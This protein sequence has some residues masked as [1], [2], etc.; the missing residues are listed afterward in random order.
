[1]R[2]SGGPAFLGTRMFRSLVLLA[3]LVAVAALPAAA[4]GAAIPAGC[5]GIT[6]DPASLRQAIVSA[7]S[8]AGPDTVVLGDSCVY[9][10]SQVQMDNPWYGPNGLPPI[11][12]D[13][14][15]EGNGSTIARRGL[16]VFNQP[17]P[18]RLF[19]VGAD[20]ASIA[21][22][23]YATPGAGKLTLR[24]VMLTGGLA[25][26]GSAAGGGGGAGAG[27]AIFNQGTVVI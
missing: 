10:L 20:P 4:S 19:F 1:M 27:G 22:L 2:T 14:T 24:N 3:G 7:N 9:R 16:T 11:A 23:N 12:S 25:K 17:P 6:G 15:I 8:L 13:I 26:G 5:T 18:F 21:T